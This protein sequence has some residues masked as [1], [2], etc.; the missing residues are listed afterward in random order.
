MYLQRAHSIPAGAYLEGW[1]EAGVEGSGRAGRVAC[2]G[3][4]ERAGP[5]ENG[6]GRTVAMGVAQAPSVG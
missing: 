4:W 1:A 2:W 3:A 6:S 5:P